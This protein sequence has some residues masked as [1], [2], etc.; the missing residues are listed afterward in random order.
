MNTNANANPTE[1]PSP[2]AS[3][4]KR[5]AFRE[6]VQSRQ[7]V[8][9]IAPTPARI[10][11]HSHT[12]GRAYLSEVDRQMALDSGYPVQHLVIGVTADAVTVVAQFDFDLVEVARWKP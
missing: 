6:S 12:N 8:E 10:V 5:P 1:S 11:Y 4:P 2:A 7:N 3:Q 9:R